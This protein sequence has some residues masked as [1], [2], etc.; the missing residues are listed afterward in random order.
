MKEIKFRLT[1]VLLS[2]R[3]QVAEN[4]DLHGFSTWLFIGVAVPTCILLIIGAAIL[5]LTIRRQRDKKRKGNNFFF[6]FVS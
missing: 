5:F 3:S 6:P 1:L 2:K 4:A